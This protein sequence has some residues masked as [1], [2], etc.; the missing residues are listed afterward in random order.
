MLAPE[1]R[2]ISTT[3]PAVRDVTA[4]TT[5]L[6]A[7]MCTHLRLGCHDDTIVVFGMLEIALSSD[8]VA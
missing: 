7:V 2:H 3:I 8:Q 4:I 5:A 1:P 6:A